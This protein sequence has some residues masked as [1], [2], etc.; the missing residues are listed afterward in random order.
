MVALF[1][2]SFAQWHSIFD[3]D[4]EVDCVF[5][6]CLRTVYPLS[7]QTQEKENQETLPFSCYTGVSQ[8]KASLI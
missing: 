7:R 6:Q 1:P 4:V 8:D 5:C 3:D 2:D